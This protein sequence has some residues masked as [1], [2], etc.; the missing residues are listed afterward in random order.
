MQ[1]ILYVR[2]AL[3]GNQ[4]PY[5]VKAQ[6]FLSERNLDYKLI[7][8]DLEHAGLLQQVKNA[9]D[10]ATV[11]MIFSRSENSISFIGGYT[12]LVDLF[13]IDEQQ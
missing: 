12:D 1:Y 5:C 9:Y 2:A 8:F 13:N 11:P 10:W 6:E 7:T 3:D 4:C